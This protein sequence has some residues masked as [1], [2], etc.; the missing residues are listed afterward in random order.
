[1][2]VL[3]VLPVLPV[4]AGLATLEVHV[5]DV[6]TDT[7]FAGNPL[8]VVL[9]GDALSP[10]QRQT[11]ARELNL[12]ETAFVLPV[13]SS[14]PAAD[15]RLAIHT[16]SVEL[17]FAGHPSVGAAWVATTLGLVTPTDGRVVMECGAGLLPLDAEGAGWRLY[18]GAP[19]LS[20]PLDAAAWGAVLGVGAVSA[21]AAGCGLPWVVVE[22][23]S[24][25][26]VDA[27]GPDVRA[28]TALAASAGLRA[29]VS[30]FALSGSEAYVRVFAL[31]AGVPEDPATG[32][33]ALALGVVLR[34]RGVVGEVTIRQGVRMGRPSTISLR[35][36]PAALS[37]AG[38][39]VPIWS[40]R[41]RVP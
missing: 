6:F 15:Y 31:D 16:P 27:A 38:T 5:V 14:P 19:S 26:E 34:Q 18:G 3:P 21:W 33:A 4:L 22:V 28:L 36:E 10:G 13:S 35:I 20:G 25:A 9:G 32:S 23:A 30:V 17:P 12:S 2:T 29:E 8:G 40:G 39:V 7:A 41:I 11:I 24:R 37:V 1:M